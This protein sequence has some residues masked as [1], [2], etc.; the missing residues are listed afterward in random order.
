MPSQLQGIVYDRS[1]YLHPFLEKLRINNHDIAGRYEA[2]RFIVDIFH[3]EK[4]T[5]SKCLSSKECKYHPYLTKFD[6]VRGMN[7]ETAEQS[8][9][10]INVYKCSTKKMTYAKRLLFFKFVDHTHNIRLLKKKAL[11]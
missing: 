1:C 7:T 5:R 11:P 9:K 6:D 3:V 4:H 10:E 8:F 2:M